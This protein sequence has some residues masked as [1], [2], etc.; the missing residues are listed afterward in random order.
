ML[1]WIG[2]SVAVAATLVLG[3]HIAQQYCSAPKRLPAR[4]GLD[5][6]PSKLRLPRAFLWT[7]PAI[8]AVVLTI[9]TVALV[10]VP[11]S[12]NQEWFTA[13]VFIIIAEVAWLMAWTS[14]RQIE[15]ARTMTYRIA[16]GRLLLVRAPMF[17][18]VAVALVLALRS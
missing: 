3:Q 9:L 13:L 14:D 11:P 8:L 16:P 5:G 6:R 17:A 2:Y 10:S 15:L 4:I 18:T 1:V 7:Y 12:A